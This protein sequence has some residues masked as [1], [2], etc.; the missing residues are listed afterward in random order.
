[1]VMYLARSGLYERCRALARL[2]IWVL[3]GH[4]VHVASTW[5][6]PIRLGSGE[7]RTTKW[8]QNFSVFEWSLTSEWR[9]VEYYDLDGHIRY[10]WVMGCKNC[11]LIR[12]LA[13]VTDVIRVHQ[14]FLEKWF[15]WSAGV[16][17]VVPIDA[18][19]LTVWSRSSLGHWSWSDCLAM[20]RSSLECCF[21]LLS[22][23][24]VIWWE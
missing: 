18:A 4:V 21:Y 10:L 1:M 19:Q 14:N 7:P 3:W 22:I 8:G 15:W 16:F 17:S 5:L 6:C 2:A 12:C 9:E 23:S 24:R 20:V 11:D 13:D